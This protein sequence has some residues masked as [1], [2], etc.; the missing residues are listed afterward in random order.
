ML[1]RIPPP[2]ASPRSPRTSRAS[3]RASQTYG[4]SSSSENCASSRLRRVPVHRRAHRAVLRLEELPERDRPLGGPRDRADDELRELAERP[5]DV[6][7]ARGQ[8]RELEELEER[9]H[10]SASRL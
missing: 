8:M 9:L 5:R 2:G 4:C 7:Q 3:P 6:L 1:P 10:A